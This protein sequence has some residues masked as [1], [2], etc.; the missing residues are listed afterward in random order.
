MIP[1][2]PQPQD[3]FTY[4]WLA[5]HEGMEQDMETI[6]TG[7]RRT[8]IRMHSFIPDS[9]LTKGKFRDIHKVITEGPLPEG[10]C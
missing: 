1:S 10:V 8:A 5:G 4:L 7:Y 2:L 3:P 9:W 6:I